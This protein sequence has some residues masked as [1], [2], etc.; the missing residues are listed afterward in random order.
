M[1]G[2]SFVHVV[3]HVSQL[4]P[5]VVPG[6]M[7]PSPRNS[8]ATSARYSRTF[9]SGS[10]PPSLATL[11]SSAVISSWL[12]VRSSLRSHPRPKIYRCGASRRTRTSSCS[13]AHA[14][15]SEPAMG[16]FR[17][18]ADVFFSAPH[19][20]FTVFGLGHM[21]RWWFPL[22]GGKAYRILGH[23]SAQR[24]RLKTH[25]ISRSRS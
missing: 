15:D 10:C 24:G 20:H 2:G 23:L 6:M 11:A 13:H 9:K 4:V 25:E 19:L 17:M 21:V 14:L 12:R 5:D 8:R 3:L 7:G 22:V 18:A 16:E 1:A